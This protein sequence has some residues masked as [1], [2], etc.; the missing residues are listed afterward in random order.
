M[1]IKQGLIIHFDEAHRSDLLK[2][3]KE[4][5]AFTREYMNFLISKNGPKGSKGG[6]LITFK[7]S[8]GYPANTE[9][10]DFFNRGWIGSNIMQ[11]NVPA[12]L[13]KS[14]LETGRALFAAE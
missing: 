11:S 14:F 10:A 9:F 4:G 2:E 13:I 8:P 1:S 5:Q 6:S 7:N 3:I 12:Q